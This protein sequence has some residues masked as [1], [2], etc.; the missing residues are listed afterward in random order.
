[1]QITCTMARKEVLVKLLYVGWA[2][3]ASSVK[4]IEQNT[5]FSTDAAFSFVS[6]CWPS[7]RPSWC[8]AVRYTLS[9]LSLL[10]RAISK[11]SFYLMRSALI[12]LSAFG[13]GTTSEKVLNSVFDILVLYQLKISNFIIVTASYILPR[14]WAFCHFWSRAVLKGRLDMHLIRKPPTSMDLHCSYIGLRFP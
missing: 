12:Y 10:R 1:M 9:R 4:W 6:I 13:W 11:P 7:C 8:P 14:T 2:C 5:L 3:I